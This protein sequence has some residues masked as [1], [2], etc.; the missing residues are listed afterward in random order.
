MQIPN[1]A[2]PTV[3]L[4]ALRAE[5]DA[6][7]QSLLSLLNQRALVAE[8]VGDFTRA[9][10]TPFF[11]PDRVAQVIEKIR[12]ANQGPL[13]GEH[14]AVIWREIMSACLALEAPQRIAYLGPSGTFSE[15]AAV[16]FFGSSIQHVPCTSFDE[17]FHAT[18]SGAA[19]F[20][21]K[22][23]MSTMTT[24]ITN[25]A[26]QVIILLAPLPVQN[27]VCC[28]LGSGGLSCMWRKPLAIDFCKASTAASLSLPPTWS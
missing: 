12:L 17:V 3:S 14:V 16:R 11:R 24:L 18:T 7:D 15:E 4:A 26:S 27:R 10:G 28:P 8:Q 25:Q 5:I 1:D 19:Q 6:L 21:A 20:R 23:P 13:K 22:A 2:P 9:E